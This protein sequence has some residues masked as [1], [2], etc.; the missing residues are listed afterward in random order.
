MNDMHGLIFAYATGNLKEFTEHRAISSLPFGC[1]Y[2]LIDFMLSNMVNADITDVGVLMRDNYQSLLDHLGSGKDFDLARKRGGLRLLPPFGY[3]DRMGQSQVFSGNMAAL[4]NV[5]KYLSRIRQEYVVMAEGA[6]VA[7]LPLEDA[8][9]Q[10]ID[11]GADITLFCKPPHQCAVEYT[12][13]LT[14]DGQ[15]RIVDIARGRASE[16]A[17]EMLS[18]C[19]LSKSKLEM[20]VSY[21]AAHNL[22]D[23]VRDVL[24]SMFSTLKI[25][26]YVFDGYAV[27]ISTVNAYFKHNMDLLRSDVRASLFLKDRPI[28]TKVRDEASTYYGPDAKVT[29]ALVADGCFIEGEVENSVIFR[30]VRIHPGVK[31]QNSILMQDTKVFPGA[32]LGYAIADKEVLVGQGRMLMGQETYPIAISKGTV[33]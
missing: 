6:L 26:G 4:A 21:C 17:L 14:L 32:I 13:Y 33:V 10:H 25:Y 19:I 12:S 9:R 5:S 15:G 24:Q 30:G 3:A 8:L 2:R 29:N 11:S 18:V 22:N 23:F 20:L 28:K 1:R 31:V 16:D 27:Q 7:N